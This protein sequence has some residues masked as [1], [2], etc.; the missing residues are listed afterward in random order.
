MKELELLGRVAVVIG[1]TSG[2]GLALSR[3]L[4]AAGADVVPVSRRAAMVDEAAAEIE[5]LGRKSLR[6]TADASI[7]RR[8]SRR[9]PAT[10]SRLL[11]ASTSS[12]TA[13]ASRSARRRSTSRTRSGTRSSTPTSPARSAPAQVFGRAHARARLRPHHQH[14][15]ARVVRRPPRSRRLHGEQVR[16]RRTD[17]R[18]RRRVGTDAAS[19]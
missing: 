12:S 8:S 16:R 17:A 6:V 19:T 13:R 18:A 10:L 5:A 9:S 7:A 1:G 15:L 14:R 3:G 11:R 2:I 4:A